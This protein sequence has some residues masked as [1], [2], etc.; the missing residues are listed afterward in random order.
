MQ[1]QW[2]DDNKYSDGLPHYFFRPHRREM[3][4]EPQLDNARYAGFLVSKQ[5]GTIH[6][7]GSTIVMTKAPK[8]VLALATTGVNG[9]FLTVVNRHSFRAEAITVSIAGADVTALR[10][11]ET[12]TRYSLKLGSVHVGVLDAKTVRYFE[13][14]R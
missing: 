3:Y 7:E 1:F 13:I 9:R 8:D 5:L 6:P 11:L 12:G 14:V 2:A 4:S 10:D